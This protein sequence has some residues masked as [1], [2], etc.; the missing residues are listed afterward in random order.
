MSRKCLAIGLAAAVALATGC[1]EDPLAEEGPTPAV[2]ADDASPA[3]QVAGSFRTHALPDAGGG[4]ADTSASLRMSAQ[5]VMD[6]ANPE[7]LALSA[8]EAAWLDKHAYPTPEELQLID[9]YDTQALEDALRNHRDA[10]AGVLLGHQM[11]ARGDLDN[12]A[13]AF[14]VAA[15]TGSLHALQQHA[16][17]ELERVRARGGDAS[18]MTGAFVARM[19]MSRMLGD[20]NADFLIQRYAPDFDRRRHAAGILAQ[21]TE[22]MRQRGSDAQVRGIPSVGPD[23]RPNGQ[24]WRRLEVSTELDEFQVY[25]RRR[26]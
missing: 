23:P 21:I 15:R 14:R 16:I 24:E 20:H 10:K 19:E 22:F 17:V 9:T 6:A 2:L 25:D 12:A 5:E 1:S 18:G 7:L 8:D 3:S 11:V 26:R 13:S 4:S